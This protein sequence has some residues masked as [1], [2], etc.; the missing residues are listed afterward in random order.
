MKDGLDAGSM[1]SIMGYSMGD[2]EIQENVYPIL[3]LTRRFLKDS[4]G[5]G[6]YRGGVGCFLALTPHKTNGIMFPLME[7]RRLVPSHGTIGGY[8]GASHHLFV[9]RQVD[10]SMAIRQGLGDPDEVIPKLQLLPAITTLQ[11]GPQDIFV[12]TSNAGGGFGDPLN[13][14]PEKVARDLLWR[15]VSRE[16]AKEIYGVV[17]RPGTLEVDEAQTKLE[18]EKI[19]ARRAPNGDKVKSD[20]VAS[21]GDGVILKRSGEG[22][23]YLCSRCQQKLS[24]VSENWK[25]AVSRKDLRMDETGVRIP[26]ND[27]IVLRQYICPECG[28][29][30]DSEVTLKS[31]KPFWDYRPIK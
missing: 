20:A 9:G 28:F 15:F 22:D 12:Y 8:P 27:R 23:V 24:S 29:L 4:G 19:R 25:E 11:M 21:D 2:V 1:L 6:R 3:Y 26:G 5:P 17:F 30:L 18:K 31:L 13:R 10:M 16:K 7:D 14:D